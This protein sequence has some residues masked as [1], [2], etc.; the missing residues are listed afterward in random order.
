MSYRI[1]DVLAQLPPGAVVPQAPEAHLE[2]TLARLVGPRSAGRIMKQ[3]GAVGIARWNA[4]ELS[5]STGVSLKVA[6]RIVAARELG[7]ASSATQPVPCTSQI[8]VRRMVPWL[9]HFETEVIL[10]IVLD[11]HLHAKATV[12]IGKGGGSSAAI[13]ARDV[14]MPLVRL[15]ASAFVLVHN[16]PSGNPTP[17]REDVALTNALAKAGQVLGI[18]LIDHIIVAGSQ[19]VSFLHTALLPTRRELAEAPETE[20]IH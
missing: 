11:G 20:S 15:G 9:G 3:A 6:E 4:S 8:D 2:P 10:A 13:H 19:T 5:V 7:V 16:H 17:S 12:L 1:E 18:T 14:F